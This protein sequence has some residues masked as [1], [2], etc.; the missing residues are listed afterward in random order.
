LTAVKEQSEV[1]DPINSTG[2]D[3]ID[4]ALRV[5]LGLTY[6]ADVNLARLQQATDFVTAVN[7]QHERVASGHG[8]AGLWR[9]WVR[10]FEAVLSGGTAGGR[11]AAGALTLLVGVGVGVGLTL[12]AV[13][14]G[15]SGPSEPAIAA[16]RPSEP[17]TVYR[18]EGGSKLIVSAEPK[19]AAARLV[20]SMVSLGCGASSREVRTTVYVEIDTTPAGCNGA[21]PVIAQ[22]GF[23]PEANGRMTVRFVPPEK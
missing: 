20:A 16:A 4:D 12:M 22:L 23:A 11:L 3:R 6:D 17:A 15:G 7:A 5:N 8:L 13:R 10:W 18:G 1:G 21:L 19:A 2:T 14:H 9:S